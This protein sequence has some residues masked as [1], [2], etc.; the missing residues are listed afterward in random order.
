MK[1]H[2]EQLFQQFYI[3][4]ARLVALFRHVDL[5]GRF[6]SPVLIAS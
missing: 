3:P 5:L 1:L 4:L 6:F 2:D